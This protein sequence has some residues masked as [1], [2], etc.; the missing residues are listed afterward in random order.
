MMGG[1]WVWVEKVGG[2]AAG[3]HEAFNDGYNN[4]GRI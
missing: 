2:A 3:S 4:T 1:G